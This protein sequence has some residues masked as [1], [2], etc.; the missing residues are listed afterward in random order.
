MNVIRHTDKNFA[1]KLRELTSSSSLFDKTIEERTRA[2]VDAVYL[3]GDAALLEFTQKFDG[4]QL[5]TEQLAV[6][7]AEFMA[8]SLKADDDLR[9]AINLA[10]KN[11]STFAK[12]S[13]RKRWS[14]VNAQGARVGE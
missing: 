6:T 11:I 1:A 9:A 5:S 8:A 13:L 4:A 12:R 2:I 7:Q 14:A 3:R 10:E